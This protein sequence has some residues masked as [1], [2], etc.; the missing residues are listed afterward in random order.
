[1]SLT[2]RTAGASISMAPMTTE[3]ATRSASLILTP[4]RAALK[5]GSV[6]P[7]WKISSPSSVTSPLT[8]PRFNPVGASSTASAIARLT[9]PAWGAAEMLGGT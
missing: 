7:A 6:R 9:L 8:V 5:K 2:A 4:S 1:M 3:R